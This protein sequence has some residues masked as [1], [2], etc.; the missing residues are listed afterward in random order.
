MRRLSLLAAVL[1]VLATSQML[2][3]VTPAAAEKMPKALYPPGYT[4]TYHPAY[5]NIDV[6]CNWNLDCT[7]DDAPVFHSTTVEQLG[8][9]GGSA[10]AASNGD[11]SVV[12]LLLISQ[13]GSS[14]GASSAVADLSSTLT[15]RSGMQEPTITISG[16]TGAMSARGQQPDS[17]IYLVAAYEGTMEVEA[18]VAWQRP[19]ATPWKLR[20]QLRQQV[21]WA[22]QHPWVNTSK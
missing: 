7:Q 15:K 1:A 17:A 11:G 12:F 6:D 20:S 21:V 16:A 9:V 3:G 5:S 13:Y 22:L 19:Y 18:A 10:Q 8:R 4:S 2:L 14:D